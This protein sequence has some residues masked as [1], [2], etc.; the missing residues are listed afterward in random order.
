MLSASR[1]PLQLSCT[2]T[3]R[4]QASALCCH[5]RAFGAA[6]LTNVDGGWQDNDGNALLLVLP[7]DLRPRHIDPNQGITLN[8]PRALKPSR[9]AD[10][11]ID[12]MD[13]PG[14]EVL[15]ALQLNDGGTGGGKDRS[16]ISDG[17]PHVLSTAERQS[18][19]PVEGRNDVRSFFKRRHSPAPSAQ[20]PR[21]VYLSFIARPAPVETAYLLSPLR[22]TPLQ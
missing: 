9:C 21:L 10:K 4:P 1:D 14:Y 18:P 6:S 19:D 8:D 22:R 16:G 5:Q 2:T 7:L 3:V 17:F 12:D 11:R 15:K 20:N 13:P